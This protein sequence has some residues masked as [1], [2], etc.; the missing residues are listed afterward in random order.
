MARLEIFRAGRHTANSGL[1]FSFSESDLANC[2]QA[3]D[4]AKHEAPLVVGHPDAS[5]PA[6]GWVQ[7]LSFSQGRLSAETAQVDPEFQEM[8]NAGRF[9][10]ISA[11][12]YLP[13]SPHNP[14][15]GGL[16]LRH[17]GFLGAQPPAV[18]GLKD[19]A[20]AANEEGVV[21]FD[22]GADAVRMSG[23]VGT[24]FRDLR[25]WIINKFGLEDAD[26]AIPKWSLGWLE[27]CAA[28]ALH[29]ITGAGA[30]E[31]AHDYSEAKVNELEKRE[32]DLKTRE[33]ALEARE[34][35][36]KKAEALSFCE[37]LTKAGRV[38]PGHA[39][40]LAGLLAKLEGDTAEFCEGEKLPAAEW[41]RAFLGSLPERVTFSEAAKAEHAEPPDVADFAV[42]DGYTVDAAKAKLHSDALAWQAKHPGT[43]LKTAYKAVGRR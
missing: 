3:Y 6:Y 10:K 22:A 18:K 40:P 35:E 33:A 43:D 8:V 14:A 13:D 31:P 29:D 34:L 25:E 17:V 38:A 37:G 4:P 16:Y 36:T 32:A 39:K 9:K 26:A 5:K 24:M 27:D 30:T 15:P 11:S 19:A 21:S 42:A 28:E 41:L 1:A 2:V 20:F 23:D 7:S 12:F